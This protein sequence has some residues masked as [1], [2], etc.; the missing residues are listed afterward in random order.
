MSNVTLIIAAGVIV[1]ISP[2]LMLTSQGRPKAGQVALVIS[3]PWGPNAA[4]IAEKSG[5]QEIAPERAPLGVLVALD[6]DQS[7]DRLYSN[8]AW[9]VINGKEV[10]EL[11]SI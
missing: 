9:L 8:G 3:A 10:L 2:I 7:V 11:C 1:M 4:Q 6:S 5:V